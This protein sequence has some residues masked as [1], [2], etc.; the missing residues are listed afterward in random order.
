MAAAPRRPVD[1]TTAWESLVPL[2]GLSIVAHTLSPL[3]SIPAWAIFVYY[4]YRT[5]EASRTAEDPWRGHGSPRPYLLVCIASL[6]VHFVTF[7]SLGEGSLPAAF[8]P[9]SL[10]G[11]V[12][13]TT[14]AVF[15]ATSAPPQVRDVRSWMVIGVVSIAGSAAVVPAF[16][17]GLLPPA[18]PSA[19]IAP[20][21]Q[22]SLAVASLGS[23]L[24][25]GRTARRR[26]PLVARKA[27][28]PR[29]GP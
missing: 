5:L 14:A 3:F 7:L 29:R 15:V 13:L 10:A 19:T 17:F 18:D 25:A 2:Y 4:A 9:P 23:F 22:I 1:W 27:A 28:V 11:L 20:L 6:T 21:A 26:V 24:V 8:V 16:L 12:V